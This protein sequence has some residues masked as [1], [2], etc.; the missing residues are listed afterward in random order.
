MGGRRILSSFST[1]PPVRPAKIGPGFVCRPVGLSEGLPGLAARARSGRPSAAAQG[2]PR[3]PAAALKAA[4]A[5]RVLSPVSEQKKNR[6]PPQATLGR[7]GSRCRGD[8]CDWAG[9]GRFHGFS[10]QASELS[11]TPSCL[12]SG[13]SALASRGGGVSSRG[14]PSRAQDFVWQNGPGGS[15][16]CGRGGRG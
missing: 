6:P 13:L 12:R 9:R 5:S 10:A 11:R 3:L 7:V 16:V 14:R 2:A 4:E 8:F 15:F 1:G